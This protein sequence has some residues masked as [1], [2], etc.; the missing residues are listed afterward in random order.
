MGNVEYSFI[1]IAPRSILAQS[2]YAI[3]P[4]QTIWWWASSLW[5]L[6]N[7]DYLFI[8]ITPRSTIYQNDGTY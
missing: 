5:A 1:A 2:G 6:G 4:N 3:K 7:L 8:A